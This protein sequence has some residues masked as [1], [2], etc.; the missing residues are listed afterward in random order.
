MAA[1]ASSQIIFFIAATILAAAISTV[2]TGVVGETTSKL[3]Q[4]SAAMGDVLVTSISIVN[5]PSD[6]PN[7]PVL[8]YVQNDGQ[9]TL[10]QTNVALIIDGVAQT[11][12]ATLLGGATEWGPTTVAQF[13]VATTLAAGD[14]QVHAAT[15][16][17]VGADLRFKE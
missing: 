4:K 13:S 3:Q 14:H 7:N 10:S 1:E 16:N 5:D 9:N 12:T 15:A 8:I 17:G 2:L 6:V 11:Y